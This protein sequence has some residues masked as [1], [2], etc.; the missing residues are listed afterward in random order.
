VTWGDKCKRGHDLTAENAIG[1][2]HNAARRFCRLCRNLRKL[3]SLRRA[4]L[5]PRTCATCKRPLP[6]SGTWGYCST[7]C[8]KTARARNS[9]GDKSH[10]DAMRTSRLLALYDEL[11]RASTSWDRADI[12]ARIEAVKAT[13]DKGDDTTAT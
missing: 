1:Y 7:P 8:E 11:E 12:R 3:E 6:H 10:D 5:R 2:D 13:E 9:S 4:A